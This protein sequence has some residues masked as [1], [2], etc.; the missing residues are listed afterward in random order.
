MIPKGVVGGQ[1]LVGLRVACR[2]KAVE[3]RAE[4]SQANSTVRGYL[5]VEPT[6]KH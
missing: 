5:S 2:I 1:L 6:A 4:P 3:L